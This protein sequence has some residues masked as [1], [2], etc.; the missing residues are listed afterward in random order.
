[1]L[2]GPSCGGIESHTS[3]LGMLSPWHCQSSGHSL[4]P[5]P[6]APWVCGNLRGS[7]YPVPKALALVTHCFQG[8][9]RLPRVSECLCGQGWLLGIAHFSFILCTPMRQASGGITPRDYS[10]PISL[11][12]SVSSK[13]VFFPLENHHS[14]FW[15]KLF[16]CFLNL[17][18]QMWILGGKNQIHLSTPNGQ[19]SAPS[20][21]MSY[22]F[23]GLFMENKEDRWWEQ[24]VTG[25]WREMGSEMPA[26]A[27]R[28]RGRGSF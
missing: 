7:L 22:V 27:T 9:G 16:F 11:P 13:L 5:S 4:L 6:W 12:A 17:K 25:S 18:N 15:W 24:Q 26:G 14:I 8:M 1:M 21:C 23:L 3:H 28:L 20:Y 2:S 10:G 19:F